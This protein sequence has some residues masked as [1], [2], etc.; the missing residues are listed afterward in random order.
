MY[1]PDPSSKDQ[2][3]EQVFAG[4]NTGIKNLDLYSDPDLDSDPDPDLD[5][6]S[7]PDPDT[8]PDDP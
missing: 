7:D 6:D 1:P 8:D 4:L 5:P 3:W 2:F